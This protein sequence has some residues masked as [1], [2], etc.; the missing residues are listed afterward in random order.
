VAVVLDGSELDE[1][2]MARF[3]RWTNL[4]ETTFLLP[5]TDAV[6]DYRVR[7]FSP[8]GEMPFAGHPTLGSAHAWVSSGGVPKDAGSIVQECGIGLVPVRYG[9][10]R[11]AFAAPALLRTG[12]VEADVL[13][14]MVTGLGL[15]EAS[16]V[17]HQWV[18]N[19]P[20]WAALLLASADEVLSL[21]PDFAALDGLKVGVVAPEPVGAEVDFPPSG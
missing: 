19:G 17:D 9:G 1:E 16:V 18:D 20:G 21:D 5:P 6:A 4:S 3:A 12:P 10:G 11:L 15:A 13:A 2:A 14:R 7:I 8:G